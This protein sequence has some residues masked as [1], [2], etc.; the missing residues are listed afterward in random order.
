MSDKS[1]RRDVLLIAADL[2]ERRLLFG[3]LLEAG[4][5]VVPIPD[6]ERALGEVLQHLVEPGL[7]LIDVGD[8]QKLTPHAVDYLLKAAPAVPVIVLVGTI[9]RAEW[10]TM[11]PRLAALLRRPITIGAIVETVK[12]VLPIP[13]H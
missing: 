4:Y 3:E 2:D 11:T 10:E 5:D 6:F 13:Q 12:G 1:A 9:N 7:I 8:D